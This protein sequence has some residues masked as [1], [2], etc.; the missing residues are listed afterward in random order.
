MK[1]KLMI[2]IAVVAVVIIAYQI[3]QALLP[4]EARIRRMVFQIQDAFNEGEAGTISSYLTSDF[5]DHETGLGR[6]EVRLFL[7]QFFLQERQKGAPKILVEVAP[8]DIE[9]Q[10]ENKDPPA[11]ELIVKARFF[12]QQQSGN[13]APHGTI[14]FAGHLKKPQGDWLISRSRH[15]ILEGRMPFR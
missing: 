12:I 4:E 3:Y 7:L 5:V 1:R 9:I 6:D 2:L 8:E 10:L 11:A 15:E 13:P 14:R